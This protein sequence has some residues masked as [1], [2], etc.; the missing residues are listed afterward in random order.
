DGGATVTTETTTTSEPGNQTPSDGD[1]GGATPGGEEPTPTP[2]ATAT[3]TAAPTTTSCDS[4]DR[5]AAGMDVGF[6][7]GIYDSDTG[8]VIGNADVERVT[9]RFPDAE[10]EP[11]ELSWNGPHERL[12]ADGWGG[13]LE[14]APETESG[15]YRY[16]VSV[17]GGDESDVDATVTDRFAIV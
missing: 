3:A 14:T 8:N 15:T 9:V 5:F 11:V 2:T 6:H 16:E 10:F 12:S 1:D 4:I 17:E 7:V 13:K